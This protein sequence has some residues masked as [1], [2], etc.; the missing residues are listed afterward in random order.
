M[1]GSLNI[2][3]YLCCVETNETYQQRQARRLGLFKFFIKMKKVV[4]YLK[5]ITVDDFFC[6]LIMGLLIIMTATGIIMLPAALVAKDW[7][8]A[9]IAGADIFATVVAFWVP[10]YQDRD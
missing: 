4:A 10:W 2:S 7:G 1:F 5:S 6:A 3:I 8:A 9:F